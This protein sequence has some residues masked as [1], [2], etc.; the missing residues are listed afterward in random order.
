MKTLF[1]SLAR[2]R[3]SFATTAAARAPEA[4]DK[5][6]QRVADVPEFSTFLAYKK[7]AVESGIYSTRKTMRKIV[8]LTDLSPAEAF[9]FLEHLFGKKCETVSEWLEVANAN[10]KIWASSAA[11][12]S[13]SMSAHK[14]LYTLANSSCEAENPGIPIRIPG[15]T[16]ENLDAGFSV[17]VNKLL[18]G[19]SVRSLDILTQL[20]VLWKS[21]DQIAKK[22]FVD[23]E[24][25]E[26]NFHTREKVKARVAEWIER[27]DP[28]EVDERLIEDLLFWTSDQ[29]DGLRKM[30]AVVE[31]TSKSFT[32]SRF[33]E[34]ADPRKL[35]LDP[36]AVVDQF[37][38]TADSAN[39]PSI[40]EAHVVV[41]RCTL[42]PFWHFHH[43]KMG[44]S[45]AWAATKVSLPSSDVT[46]SRKEWSLLHEKDKLPYYMRA[47]RY[48][49]LFERGRSKSVPRVTGFDIY[50]AETGLRHADY[51]K[52]ATHR[53][54]YYNR[55]ASALVARHIDPEHFSGGTTGVGVYASGAGNAHLPLEQLKESFQFLSMF[56]EDESFH[57]QAA[58]NQRWVERNRHSWNSPYGYNRSKILRRTKDLFEKL[59]PQKLLELQEDNPK[60]VPREQ[61]EMYTQQCNSRY[62]QWDR[63]S[64]VEI[65]DDIWGVTPLCDRFDNTTPPE[66]QDKLVDEYIMDVIVHS[67]NYNEREHLP[68]TIVECLSQELRIGHEK[69][70]DVFLSL[71]P[72][73]LAYYRE[74]CL[75]NVRMLEDIYEDDIKVVASKLLLAEAELVAESTGETNLFEFQN[76]LVEYSEVRIRLNMYLSL[77]VAWENEKMYYEVCVLFRVTD[78]P[79]CRKSTN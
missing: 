46:K 9:W 70:T 4:R 68:L 40:I 61:R 50:K 12:P 16:T 23:E 71:S 63:I 44:S 39:P 2:S 3:R 38:S 67:L 31:A 43:E 27:Q 56:G 33:T 52:L 37:I 45:N 14:F 78:L 19:D 66:Q 47:R 8:T 55:R 54:D 57:L 72:Q 18:S 29:C 51:L 22:D 48:Y 73:L 36:F 11:M 30:L 74:K 24:T 1:R 32:H 13:R 6:V 59:T 41:R 10:M 76:K 64:M 15:K 5:G 17:F 60:R 42:F 69:A 34:D 21:L 25:Q 7:S 35:Y 79:R 77:A 53:H 62:T 49:S 20:T 58:E 26:F 65:D 75:T 28:T